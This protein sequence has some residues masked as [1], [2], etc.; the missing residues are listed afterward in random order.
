MNTQNESNTQTDLSR[1]LE[2]ITEI[3]EKSAN[4]N[5]IYRGEPECY[6]KVSSSLYRKLEELGLPNPPVEYIQVTELVKARRYINKTE[7]FEVLTEI[8]HFAGKTNLIDFTT[9]YYIALFFACDRSPFEDGRVILQDKNGTMSEWIEAPRHAEPGSRPD[10]QKSIFVR[11]PNGFFQ[12]ANDDIVIIP[13]DIKQSI[14]KYLKSECRISAEIIYPDLH[15]FVTSQDLRWN[16]YI[17]FSK[18]CI[19]NE[20]ARETKDPKGKDETYRKAVVRFTK[21]IKLMPEFSQSYNN[22]GTIYDETNEYNAAIR[23]YTKAIEIQPDYA[24]A[25]YN[26]GNAYRRKGE[27]EQAIKDYNTA[28]QF[29]PDDASNYYNRGLAYYKKGDSDRAIQDYSKALVLD[30]EHAD[31]YYNRGNAYRR[32]GEWTHALQDF[33]RAIEIQPNYTNA[34][35][36]R[37][38]TYGKI[39]DWTSAFQDSNTAIK[40]DPEHAD[41]YTNRGVAYRKLGEFDR[42]IQDYDRVIQLKPKSA[43]AYYNRGNAYRKLGEFDRAIQDYNKVIELNPADT[44]AYTNRGVAYHKK[45][46]LDKAIRDYNRAIDLNPKYAEAYNNRGVAYYYH[47]GDFD[48]AIR[49][50]NRSIEL[51]PEYAQAYSNRGRAWLHLREWE[52]AK[53]DLITAK[54]MATDIVASFHVDYKSIADFEAKHGAEM[55]EDIAAL[56]SRD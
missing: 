19:Y 16:A 43:D 31:A 49:D 51:N 30:P 44:E 56:L 12:P 26:R 45:G 41:A 38:A 2:K 37:G 8:Q 23:D 14:L 28:I 34:Y 4:G 40:L 27:W 18:G 24:D 13:R 10:V 9:D 20:K 25:Y 55:P 5:Y 36:N 7:D 47:K 46:N 17:E 29:K 6:G 33:T 54:N 53:A 3:A 48:T 35:N 42:A 52:K 32:K 1:V 39:G 50:Y 15:G 22:R 11:P 21:A